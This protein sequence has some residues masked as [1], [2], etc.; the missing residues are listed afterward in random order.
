MPNENEQWIFWEY[1]VINTQTHPKVANLVCQHTREGWHHYGDDRCH[2][3]HDGC[4]LDVDT[5]LSHVDRQVRVQ[6][7]QSCKR[8]NV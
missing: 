3:K 6:D 8:E 5:Q 7:K 4:L 2:S 1:F